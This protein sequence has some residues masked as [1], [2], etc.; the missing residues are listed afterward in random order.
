MPCQTLLS[1][2]THHGPVRFV[3]VLAILITDV[4]AFPANAAPEA[5]RSIR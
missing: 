3:R 5:G 2:A 4:P 1:L